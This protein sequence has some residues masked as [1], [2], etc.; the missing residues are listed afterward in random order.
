MNERRERSSYEVSS[1][2][3]MKDQQR[4]LSLIAEVENDAILIFNLNHLGPFVRADRQRFDQ[5]IGEKA[6]AHVGDFEFVG[7][8][9]E[10]AHARI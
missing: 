5:V 8:V 10:S 4:G 9:A 2:I 1:G 3:D 7:H 6:D